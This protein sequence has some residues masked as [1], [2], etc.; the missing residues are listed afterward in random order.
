MKAPTSGCVL[1]I[2]LNAPHIYADNGDSVSGQDITSST[3]TRLFQTYAV[4]RSLQD[5]S[6]P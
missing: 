2:H 4:W 1:V 3:L 5:G 6:S